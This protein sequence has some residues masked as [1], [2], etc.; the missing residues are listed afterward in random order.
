MRKRTISVSLGAMLLAVSIA[1]SAG[2]AV[3]PATTC[4]DGSSSCCPGGGGTEPAVHNT[5]VFAVVDTTGSLVVGST[6][7]AS[8]LTSMGVDTTAIDNMENGTTTVPTYNEAPGT[9]VTGLSPDQDEAAT[10]F[11]P[12]D[13]T[14]LTTP[15]GPSVNSRDEL[16]SIPRDPVGPQSYTIVAKWYDKHGNRVLVRNGYWTGSTGFGYAKVTQ[17]HNLSLEALYDVTS[18]YAPPVYPVP[19]AGT[20]VL[21]KTPVVKVT[22]S[23]WYVFR[24]CKVTASTTVRAIVERKPQ[25]D[26]QQKGIINAY[27]EGYFPRC[28]DWVKQALNV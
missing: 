14:S 26:S 12:A 11:Y 9:S 1:T 22:C 25:K 7:S 27:C 10:T 5:P 19:D 2:A 16:D 13:T 8:Q 28:P 20:S 18:R 21:Y 23:G 15:T 3:C 6:V 24:K 17:Y 4:P